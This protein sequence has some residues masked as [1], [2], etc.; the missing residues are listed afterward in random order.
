MKAGAT[1]GMC[2]YGRTD[3]TTD[4]ISN[5]HDIP[6]P[7]TSRTGSDVLQLLQALVAQDHPALVDLSMFG[8]DILGLVVTL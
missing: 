6:V 7:N 5:V 3:P 1:S 2:T 4:A 8:Q